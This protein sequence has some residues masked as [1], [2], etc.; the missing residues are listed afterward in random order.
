M[1]G[2]DE[3]LLASSIRQKYSI[4]IRQGDVGVD[5]VEGELPMNLL[6]SPSD[7]K[8]VKPTGI[9]E[10]IGSGKSD[11]SGMINLYPVTHRPQGYPGIRLPLVLQPA[12]RN[13]RPRDR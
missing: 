1:D 13:G 4:S 10:K 12:D 5:D 2:D 11:A 3:R 8:I 7:P 9:L 6:Y